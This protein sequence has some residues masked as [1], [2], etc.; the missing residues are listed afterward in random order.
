[1]AAKRQ[2]EI[3]GTERKSNK[4][5]DA[6]AEALH[7]VRTKRMKLSKKEG[8]AVVTLVSVM[9]KH[10]VEIYRDDSVTPPLLVRLKPGKDTVQVTEVGDGEGN[11][12]DPEDRN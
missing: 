11:E 2:Q 3:P 7:E 8:E 4:E 1:M 6:A 5:V 10:N 12:T 9:R